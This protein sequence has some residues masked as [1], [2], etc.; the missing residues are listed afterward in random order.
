ATISVS[1]R[2]VRAAARLP[3]LCLLEPFPTESV[4]A[5]SM[6]AQVFEPCERL[7]ER[8]PMPER[9][10]P[11]DEVHRPQHLEPFGTA[12]VQLAV[13]RVPDEILERL[14][15]LPA[16]EV[17]HESRIA[18]ELCLRV[19]GAR[20]ARTF[21]DPHEAGHALAQAVDEVERRHELGDARIV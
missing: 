6:L 21:H 5:V 3:K 10:P 20:H 7:F 2:R 17:R 19:A 11:H 15:A 18:V 16:R 9:Y 8:R 13:H 14:D 1:C 4:I 12:L